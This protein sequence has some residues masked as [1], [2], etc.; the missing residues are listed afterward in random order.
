MAMDAYIFSEREASLKYAQIA[1]SL[2]LSSYC[3][4]GCSNESLISTGVDKRG[5][6]NFR[7]SLNDIQYEVSVLYPNSSILS[8]EDFDILVAGKSIDYKAVN[9]S[10]LIKSLEFFSSEG[11]FYTGSRA[12]FTG[13]YEFKD[14]ILHIYCRECNFAFGLGSRRVFFSQGDRIF[15]ANAGYPENAVELIVNNGSKY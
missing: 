14:L 12:G 8:A 9:S 15:V 1:M 5:E 3:V 10:I 11:F 13:R 2:A 7:N 6:E 4:A